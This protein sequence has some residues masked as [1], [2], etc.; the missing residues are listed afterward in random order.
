MV[1]SAK[2]GIAYFVIVFG[3]GFILGTIRLVIFVPHL[4]ELSSTLIELPIILTAAWFI[5][6]RLLSL[7]SVAAQ[8]T[9][10]LGM[11]AIAFGLLMTAELGLSVFLLGNS[12]GEHLSAYGSSYRALGLAGQVIYATFP[13]L[14]PRIR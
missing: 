7:F 6:A 13:L 14:Q 1:P 3:V 8:W 12:V 11:G 4:G 10:R 5:C 2:A 9:S